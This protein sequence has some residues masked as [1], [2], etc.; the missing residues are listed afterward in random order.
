MSATARLCQV[1]VR[2]Q[3]VN[4]ENHPEEKVDCIVELFL[5]EDDNIEQVPQ[6]T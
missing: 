3:Y 4:G 1:R 5:T 6:D 2:S